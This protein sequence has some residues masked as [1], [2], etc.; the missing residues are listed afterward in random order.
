MQARME[1]DTV[2]TLL[3]NNPFVVEMETG[4]TWSAPLAGKLPAALNLQIM[5]L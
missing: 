2:D 4:N 5:V 1:T 3:K